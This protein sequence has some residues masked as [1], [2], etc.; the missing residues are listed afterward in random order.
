[1]SVDSGRGGGQP[2]PKPRRP[3]RPRKDQSVTLSTGLRTSAKTV[4]LGGGRGEEG[5]RGGRG[6]GGASART[7]YRTGRGGG[8]VG[9]NSSQSTKKGMKMTQYEF[10]NVSSSPFPPSLVGGGHP[11]ALQ[12]QQVQQQAAQQQPQLFQLGSGTAGVGQNLLTPLQIIPAASIPG[13][14]GV[15]GGSMLLLQNTPQGVTLAA[16]P[17]SNNVV[18]PTTLLG[19]NT[20]QL[21]QAAPMI[22]TDQ[23]E[24]A[25]KVSVIMHP[26]AGV[27]TPVQYIAQ[28]DGPPPKRK[29][30]APQSSKELHEKF[31]K[32]RKKE[33]AKLELD[34]A[35]AKSTK[36]TKSKL[37]RSKTIDSDP[38]A[39]ASGSLSEPAEKLMSSE[40]NKYL[41]MEESRRK[42]KPSTAGGGGTGS[43][44]SDSSHKT[45]ANP[46]AAARRKRP[47][48]VTKS[49]N[50]VE[51]TTET[52]EVAGD[53]LEREEETEGE[54]PSSAKK[55]RTKAK[56]KSV[57][58][59]RKSTRTRAKE[60][61]EEEGDIE[62]PQP[63]S[64]KQKKTEARDQ[65][66]AE[67]EL[68][69]A[70]VSDEEISEVAMET[71]STQVSTAAVSR[72][73]KR[74]SKWVKTES[75]DQ[76]QDE[77]KDERTAQE[78]LE[79]TV[80]QESPRTSASRGGRG[81]S[82]RKKTELKNQEEIEDE[83]TAQE[84]LEA[85]VEAES[86]QVSTAAASGR[87]SRGRGSASKPKHVCN[88]CGKEYVS[89]GRLLGHKEKT[90]DPQ[91]TVSYGIQ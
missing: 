48:P 31:D 32:E 50:D 89:H 85:T 14:H 2:P 74:H 29:A 27:G 43:S 55:I 12:Q 47:H 86:P 82:K 42:R 91:L 84:I 21:V 33:Q 77:T 49:P 68:R 61:K 10:E 6:R 58:G 25:Q 15:S 63:P 53:V 80:E 87:G 20:Y 88:E 44:V 79:A 28:F 60:E 26:T 13:Y 11:Q 7:H 16:T 1:M 8:R 57:L 35:A 9:Q 19:G 40:L 83:R 37:K 65:E 75:R 78:T 67:S 51:A 52:E 46:S 54:P 70:Q 23:G 90:H 38:V 45:K 73:G 66:E 24:N 62:Q 71:A 5:G 64:S 59:K 72:G 4:R 81:R 30:K 36:S 39:L 76:D 22:A 3:G 41:K 34:T 56:K 18:A 69:T 17:N